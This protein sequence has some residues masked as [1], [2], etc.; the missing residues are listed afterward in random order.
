M[1]ATEFTPHRFCVCEPSENS[2][3]VSALNFSKQKSQQVRVQSWLVVILPPK[4]SKLLKS[5]I[6]RFFSSAKINN[7]IFVTW[8]FHLYRSLEQHQEQGC[9]WLIEMFV[10]P[11]DESFVNGY[12]WGFPFK[13]N[14][15]GFLML[16]T[17]HFEWP[18][19]IFSRF[20]LNA[21]CP[22]HAMQ[23]SLHRLRQT[24]RTCK[25]EI[26]FKWVKNT[27]AIEKSWDFNPCQWQHLWETLTPNG[28]Y[29]TTLWIT[30]HTWE[31]CRSAT[32]SVLQQLQ[33][34]RPGWYLEKGEEKQPNPKYV[35]HVNIVI[36]ACFTNFVTK[37]LII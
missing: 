10:I 28:F 2:C 5:Q 16:F 30:P 9:G 27:F 14:I 36:V 23:K 34:S 37:G 3:D 21:A 12:Y 7:M 29:P 8:E 17:W 35:S 24:T 32:T 11:N 19:R 18:K 13:Q 26:R 20:Q 6:C 31:R 15:T 25:L 33:A 4:Y 22:N 1:L